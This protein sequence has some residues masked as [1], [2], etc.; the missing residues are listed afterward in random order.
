MTKRTTPL[1]IVQSGA[2]VLREKAKRVS[3]DEIPSQKISTIITQMKEALDAE[4][5]GVAIAAPQIGVPL[6]IFVVSR[7]AFA[8]EDHDATVRKEDV[9]RG[10]HDLVC[11][12]P[13]IVKLSKRKMKVPVGC[14]SVR[15]FYGNTMRN[16]KATIRAYDEKGR[17][18]SYGGSGIV[19]QIFQHETDHLD[20]ILF[21]DIATDLEELPPDE[22][23]K[24][25]ARK[26]ER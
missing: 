17:P 21:T 6:R 5:D 20:G 25:E 9:M 16:E 23:K 14:L 15:W 4:P 26:S 2:A 7:K 8:I 22:I 18:F 11:I 13:E 19:A 10:K 12:N 1:P 24:I 3:L